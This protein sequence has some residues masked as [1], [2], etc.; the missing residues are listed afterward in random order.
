MII[1]AASS[2]AFIAGY[3]QVMTAIHGP[4]TRVK[5]VPLL[6]VLAAGRDKYISDRSLLDKALAALA[7]RSIHIAPDMVEALR[8][9]DVKNWVFLKDT[10]SHSVFV[11]PSGHA[12]YGV[13]GLTDRIRDIVG[14]S[15]AVIETGLARYRGHYVCDGIVT[16]IVWL[17]RSYRR[18]FNAVLAE[19]RARC[20]F[21]T[22]CC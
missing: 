19:L 14:G 21:H 7:K 1:D 4:P 3:T 18:E 10:R 17:G 2:A 20:A 5:T 6:D 12:A 9:L 22:V 11:D 13:L 15:G 8:S 16:G